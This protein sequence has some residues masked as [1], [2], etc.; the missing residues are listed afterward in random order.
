MIPLAMYRPNTYEA[1]KTNSALDLFHQIS[2]PRN[3]TFQST[4]SQVRKRKH[5]EITGRDNIGD[6][7]QI[8]VDQVSGPVHYLY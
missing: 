2:D 7:F 4:T 6:P 5:D 3:L 1:D 8:Q